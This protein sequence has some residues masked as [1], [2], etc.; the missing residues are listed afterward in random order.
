MSTASVAVVVNAPVRKPSK[1]VGAVRRVLGAL[2][3]RR[4][5]VGAGLALVVLAVAFLGP[6]SP[7]SPTAFVA[8]PFTPPFTNGSG[9]LGT[10]VLGR[11]VLDRVFHGGWSLMLLSFAATLVAVGIGAVIGVVAAYRRGCSCGAWMSCSLSHSSCSH[12]CSSA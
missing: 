1:N 12:S 8:P 11:S 5:V 10:D 3:T 9:L 6:L 2:R 4:G 7:A